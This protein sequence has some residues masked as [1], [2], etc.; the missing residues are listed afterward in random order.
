MRV[1]VISILDQF[2]TTINVS[3]DVRGR[4]PGQPPGGRAD[5]RAGLRAGAAPARRG[6][7]ATPPAG[8]RLPHP[9]PLSLVLPPHHHP[10]QSGALGTFSQFVG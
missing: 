2:S 7:A 6:A 3:G 4:Q 9:R 1:K 8:A 5:E 10:A